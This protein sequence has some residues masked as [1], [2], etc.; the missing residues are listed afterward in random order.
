[1]REDGLLHRITE[2]LKDMCYIWAKEMRSTIT[3]EGVLI[4]CVLVPLFYPLLYSWIYN[5]EVVR[6][7]SVAVVDLDHSHASRQFIRMFDGG[8]DTKVAYYCNS[9]DEAKTLVGKQ[10]VHG[11]LYFPSDFEKRLNR[12][13]QA[14]VGVYCDMS[15][16]LTYKAI[17][18]TAQAVSQDINSKIQISQ[19][20]GFTNRDDEISTKPLDFDEVPIFN[21][22]GGYGN[23]ILPGVLILIL[24]QTLLLGIGLSAGTA[25][26]NNRY[27]DL[28]PISR[29]Y[30]GIFRIVL[31]KSMCYFMI[32][33]VMAAYITLCVPHFFSFTS[34]VTAKTLIGLML[35]YL[36]ACIFFGMALSCLV[37][38]R[39]NVMLLVVFTSLPFLFMTGIS[40]PQTNIPGI[41]QG[42]AW[43]FPSTFGVRGFM[44][45]NEMGASLAD[46]Q[47]EYQALWIQVVAYFFL[48][49]L[50]YRYQILHTR[51][52]AYDRL[53]VLKRKAR[54][55]RE[56]KA[57]QVAAMTAEPSGDS[58]ERP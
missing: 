37:R 48:T 38:Y 28:V 2:G 9:L 27:Q 51:R 10:A 4:F 31:G 18:Q 42:I 41:W 21:A 8:S 22:T 7:V 56:R 45:I 24:Q 6:D 15:L 17:Y 33:S 39:E 3:D 34:M 26:E 16:M 20:G 23:A 53:E 43:L 14:H 57:T 5:N 55:A 13:E 32:Y 30:N 19:S 12:G 46:I 40:W 35:P 49:C 50:V 1:M 54:E 25:R 52:H 47:V 58:T 29:H 11:V 36:L 44:R